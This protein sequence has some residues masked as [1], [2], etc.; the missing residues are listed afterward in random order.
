[1]APTIVVG[2]DRSDA[3]ESVVDAASWLASTLD[4]R[5]LV[6]HAVAEPVEE[7]EELLESLRARLP[8][9]DDT[10]T[11]LVEGAPA[12]RLIELADQEDAELLVV[13]SRGR[14][15]L[16]SAVLG[17]VSRKVAR[18]A[19]C[20]VVVV[21]PGASTGA[22]DA[23]GGSKGTVVCGVDGSGHAVTAAQVA[24]RLA[25]RLGGRLLVLHAR[26]DLKAVVSYRGARSTT[27]PVTGQEDAVRRQADLVVG[28]AVEAV[29][30]DVEATG[31]IEPGAPAG[32]LAAVADREDARLIVIA[33]R[34]MG[35]IRAAF[36]GSVTTALATSATR[37][38]VVLSEPAELALA[39]RTSGQR[40]TTA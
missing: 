37:P 32:L 10:S 29:D 19:R 25:E 22:P 5:L 38:V 11:R 40:K 27:P 7:A 2:V 24:G 12:E 9:A 13:G 23:G 26:Q 16:S 3:A 4:T 30:A 15:A 36:L 17:G 6:V 8:G 33:A 21:P 39:E 35:A 31:L 20:P 28:E 18:D 1:M 34:G 14:G